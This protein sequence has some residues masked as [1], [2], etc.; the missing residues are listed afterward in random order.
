MGKILKNLTKKEIIYALICILLVAVHVKL[1]LT[2][3]DYMSTI[4]ML[5]KTEGSKMADILEQGI[6]MISCA[7]ASLICSIIV[8][9]FAAQVASSFSATVRRKIFAKVENMGI[10]EIK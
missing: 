4:T 6:Y 2:I 8:G 3:P 7:L 10:A 9:Y 5:V 1:E